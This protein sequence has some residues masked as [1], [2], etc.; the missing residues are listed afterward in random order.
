MSKGP[1]KF[2]EDAFYAADKK[3]VTAAIHLINVEFKFQLINLMQRTKRMLQQ[4][5]LLNSF[6]F[7]FSVRVT[8]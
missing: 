7:Y 8:S 3:L 5:L 6:V 4:Q 2:L 1:D